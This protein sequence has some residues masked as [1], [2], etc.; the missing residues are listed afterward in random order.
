VGAIKRGARNLT[1]SVVRALLVT[2]ILALAVA[3]FVTMTSSARGIA[4]QTRKLGAEVQTLIEVRAAGATGMGAGVEALP[5]EFFDPA[6]A[7]DNVKAV[8]PYL[9]QRTIDRQAGTPISIFVG[10]NP[11][12]T[13]RVASHGEVGSPRVVA[14]RSLQPGDAGQPVAVVGQGYATQYGVD[15]GEEFTLPPE[16]ILTQDRAEGSAPLEPLTLRAVGIFDSGSAFGDAQV[17]L[18]LDIAQEAFDQEGRATHVFVTAASVDVVDQVEQ[19]LREAFGS[20]ADVIS[21]Q[22][23]ARTFADTLGAVQANTVASAVIAVA[24][25]AAIVLFTMALTVRERT[26]EIGVLKALGAAPGEIARQFLSESVVL[27][28]LG[29]AAGLGLFALVGTRLAG[30]L[31]PQAADLLPSMT[32]TGGEDPL[33][34]LGIDQSLTPV[35]AALTLGL[36]LVLGLLGSIYP[37]A[38]ALRLE[39]VEAMRD[40][41]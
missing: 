29:A 37:L 14:G 15:V 20:R 38:R 3:V 5:A 21:G 33:S 35:L 34:T 12:D 22:D 4:S 26:R 25:A 36:A 10:V 6:R 39:P 2:G 7:V 28:L 17:F 30:V 32:F 19:D 16:R 13:L 41:Q 1:R 24:V 31:L 23:T 11:G 27:A 18:P 8:E 9:F 40:E